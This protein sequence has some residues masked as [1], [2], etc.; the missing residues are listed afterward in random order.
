MAVNAIHLTVNRVDRPPVHIIYMSLLT[1]R[2]DVLH[3]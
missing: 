1:Q 3:P 2:D